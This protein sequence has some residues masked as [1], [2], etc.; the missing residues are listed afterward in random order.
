MDRTDA[1]IAESLRRAQAGLLEEWHL[2]PKCAKECRSCQRIAE[3]SPYSLS[4]GKNPLPG[5]PGDDATKCK[6]GTECDCDVTPETRSWENIMAP[7]EAAAEKRAEE[8]TKD[9]R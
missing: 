9:F 1:A 6:F 8:L 5:W 7:L 3:R 4:A 2:G